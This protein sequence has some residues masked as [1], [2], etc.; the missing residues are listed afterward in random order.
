MY[1]A[2]YLEKFASTETAGFGMASI[3]LNVVVEV[4]DSTINPN[5]GIVSL[6]QYC[7]P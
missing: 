6:S 3:R 1:S 2:V 5:P 4:F 7:S